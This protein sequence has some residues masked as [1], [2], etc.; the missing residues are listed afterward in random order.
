VIFPEPLE[1]GKAY[2]LTIEYG[3]GDALFDVG[4]GN[5]F[6]RPR[7]TWYPNNEGTAFGDRAT[8]DITYHYAKDRILIGT[9]APVAPPVAD[10]G[11]MMVKWSSGQT[12]LAVAGFNY[13]GL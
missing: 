11:G 13:G 8:F 3:G 5:F 4:G 12:A 10:G 2:K 1:A 7:S 6:L 9:G